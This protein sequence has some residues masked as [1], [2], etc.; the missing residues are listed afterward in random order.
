ML[1]PSRTVPWDTPPKPFV[2]W[3]GGKG[4]LI[5][6][7]KPFF[8]EKFGTY[9]EPFLGG[10]A[11]FFSLLVSARQFDAFL[12]DTNK[13]L[14]TTYSVIKDEPERLISTLA[15]HK[16]CYERAPED[17]FYAVRESEPTFNVEIAARLIFLNKTCFNGLYRVNS[18][19]KFNVPFGRYRNPAI[20]DKENLKAVS[21][22]L[23]WSKAKIACLDYSEAAKQAKKD[24]FLYFDP[25]Y[26]PVSKTANFTA[27]TQSGFSPKDQE[28]LAKLCKELSDRGCKV[29]VSN[30]NTEDVLS[31]YDDK[32]RFVV[33]T[34]PAMRAINCKGNLR[35]GHSELIIR[36]KYA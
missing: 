10:G 32:E 28:N 26:H 17:Y 1:T 11:V 16:E 7:L 6:K 31:L 9:F 12:S 25:P 3:A 35:S 8:P 23:R 27:Y 21:N 33:Q 34:V 14:I 13:E 30:S 4:Q 19:G 5:D 20:C 24:D 15:R 36:T 18:K 22:A 29:L 2:K